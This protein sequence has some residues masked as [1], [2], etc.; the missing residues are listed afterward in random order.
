M[1][2]AI[3]CLSASTAVSYLLL[4]IPT[5]AVKNLGLKPTV[6]YISTFAGALILATLTPVIGHLSDKFGRTRQMLIAGFALLFSFYPCFYV[7]T[8]FRSTSAIVAVVL[9]LSFLKSV[10]YGALPALMSELFPATTRATSLAFSYNLGVSLF[11]GCG[12][13]VMT[14]LTR[15]TGSNLAP[16]YY[17]TAV[18]ALGIASI[19]IARKRFVST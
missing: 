9:W 3:G 6:G 11:G 4:Y 19:L 17:L 15:T 10:Y 1:L 7:L 12:P 5:Y 8:A 2:I 14:W 18:A 16:S 13:L